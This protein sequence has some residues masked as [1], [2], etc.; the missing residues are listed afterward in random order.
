MRLGWQK[1]VPPAGLF[2]GLDY[3]IVYRHSELEALFRDY[4]PEGQRSLWLSPRWVIGRASLKQTEVEEPEEDTAQPSDQ[5]F[6]I[7]CLVIA[8]GGV[9]A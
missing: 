2:E 6:S 5:S 7:F 9:D 8:L 3:R 4:L 1:G